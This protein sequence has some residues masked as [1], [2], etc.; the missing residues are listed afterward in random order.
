M[1][2]SGRTSSVGRNEAHSNMQPYLAMNYQ[3]SMRGNFPPRSLET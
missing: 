3:L 1:T 2:V